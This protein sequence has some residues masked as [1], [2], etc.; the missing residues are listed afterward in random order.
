[1]IFLVLL[2]VVLLPV[3]F[4]GTL[5]LISRKP[6]NL[7]AVNG[8]LADCPARPNCVCTQCDDPGHHIDPLRFTGAPDEAMQR[9]KTVVGGL[10]RSKI[11]TANERYMHVECTS[12]L[13]RFIDDVEFLIE[14]DTKTVQF[15][16]ASRAGHS[17]LG[18]NRR[19]MEEIRQKFGE[20]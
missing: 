18:V 4:L 15:R 20:P 6:D 9:L 11:M 10:P 14:P 16:S 12:L 2:V 13:F 8:R 17:D 19:R 7:G 1:M 3:I 5:S